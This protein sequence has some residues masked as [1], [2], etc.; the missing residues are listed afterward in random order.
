M[1]HKKTFNHIILNVILKFD[2]IIENTKVK[3]IIIIIVRI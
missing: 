2:K 1:K 3:I